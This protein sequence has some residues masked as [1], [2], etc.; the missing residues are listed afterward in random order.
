MILNLDRFLQK[1]RPY[2]N[3][4]ERL[5]DRRDNQPDD[6][7]SL[8]EVRR[9]QYLYQRASSD[10]VKLRTFAGEAE[11]AR[12]LERLIA[13]SYSQLHRSGG[14]SIPFRPWRWLSRVF[15]ATFRRHWIAFALSIGTFTAGGLFG[16][17]ALHFNYEL[18]SDFIPPQFRHLNEK[19]SERVEREEEQDFDAFQ[20]RQQFSAQLMVNNIRVT[21]LAMVLGILWGAF[22][23]I[24][25]FYNGILIGIVGY[26]YIIDGQST[27]LAAWLLPHGSIE[28]PAIF[29]GG[30]AGLVIAHAVFGWGTN[31]GL[32]ERLS[33]IRSDLLTLVGGAALLL[34][35]A[36]I[37]ESFLSQY[38]DPDF[39]P[40]KIGFGLLQL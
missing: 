40:W 31:L 34:V 29:I 19:P 18:K 24:L 14:E 37:I 15:P 8:G 3:E 38:H 16:A 21:L 25:L 12:F 13:R 17:G 7:L 39:Y 1:E 26:D 35:W 36:A 23:L 6:P 33:R 10:L 30:Q 32:R 28:L 11:T 2:W 22:T 20:G 4:L 27:F 9:F 5:L